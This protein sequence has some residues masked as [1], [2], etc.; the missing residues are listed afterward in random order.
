MT[1]HPLHHLGFEA[2][3]SRPSCPHTIDGTADPVSG[4]TIVQPTKDAAVNQALATAAMP[5]YKVR[6]LAAIRD[7][8]GAEL[9]ATRARKNPRRLQA[10]ITQEGQ[11]AET[12]SDYGAAQ[13]MVD[14]PRT[15]AAVVAAIRRAFPV[16]RVQDYFQ[17]GD[18]QYRYRHY[19]MQ[20]Q[21]PNGSSEEL[22]I[23]PREVMEANR[24][25]HHV[26]KRARNATLK[27]RDLNDSAMEKFNS[28]N[29][30]NVVK[31][32]RVR[33]ADGTPA[34]V[35]YADPNMRIARVRTDEGKNLTVRHK[36]LRNFS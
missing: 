17:N 13:I 9:A 25:E 24:D 33:L 30:G 8:P 34:R 1:T 3:L 2:L 27:A 29:G 32:T 28:R 12:V 11:P 19:S 4:R 31:G 18:P 7:V 10:K 35:L 21:M 15:K 20:L 26:Y 36:D 22:Q 23:V 16:L 6:L 14:S 5:I